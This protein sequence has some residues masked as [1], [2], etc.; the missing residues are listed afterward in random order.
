MELFKLERAMG[1]EPTTSTLARSRSTP[2]LHPHRCDKPLFITKKNIVKNFFKDKRPQ[3]LVF[4]K[5]KI[6][7][8]SPRSKCYLFIKRLL[9]LTWK[10]ENEKVFIVQ[11]PYFCFVCMPC[12]GLWYKGSKTLLQPN[13]WLGRQFDNGNY[14]ILQRFYR[15][16]GY[17]NLL[18]R[19]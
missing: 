1:F 12:K 19:W 2:E 14:Q 10:R 15:G 9:Q 16:A 17:G 4:G 5:D 3:R 6:S 7:F 13:V 18:C 8:A 11:L